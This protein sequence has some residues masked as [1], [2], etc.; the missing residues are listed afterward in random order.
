M[1]LNRLHLISG[2]LLFSLWQPSDTK[3]EFPNIDYDFS[4]IHIGEKKYPELPKRRRTPSTQQIDCIYADENLYISFAIP[5]G[6]C[7]MTVTDLETGLSLQYVFDTD[8]SAEINVGS[9]SSAYL[10]LET[11]NGHSYEGWIE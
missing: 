5:E 11:E 7:N 8:E 10:E 9:L 3:A 6:E 4:V 1:K 2:V